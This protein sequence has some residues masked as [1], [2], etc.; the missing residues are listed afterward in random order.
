MRL[1]LLFIPF[2]LFATIA[3]SQTDSIFSNSFEQD[4]KLNNPSL[5]YAYDEK[6]QIHDYSN[7]WDLDNDGKKDRLYFIGTGG[8]HLYFYLRVILSSDNKVY[9]F[10]FLESDFPFLPS[11]ETLSKKT[12][13]PVNSKDWFAI[14][15]YFKDNSSSIFIQLNESTFSSEKSILKKKGIKTDLVI[16]SFKKGKPVFEDFDNL[17]D[18]NNDLAAIC[19]VC[20][21][22]KEQT[23]NIFKRLEVLADFRGGFMKWFEYATN[24]FN[25]SSVLEKL[26]DSVQLFQDSIVVKFIVTKTGK[27]CYLQTQKGNLVLSA[28]VKALLSGCPYWNPGSNGGRNLNSYRTLR[29]DVYIDKR[30]GIKKIQHYSNSYFRENEW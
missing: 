18:N 19:D 28:P 8:A 17:S 16:L 14:Y 3:Q 10:P 7:N 20:K 21:I 13:N 6:K 26:N 5:Q 25:Y 27:L 24:N 2:F 4:Y 11:A 12:F 9:N 22:N 29:I 1:L 30:K 15:D 23:E